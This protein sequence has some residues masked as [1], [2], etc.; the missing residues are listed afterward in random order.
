MNK[1]DGTII[2]K[3]RTRGKKEYNM[4]PTR[5]I[6]KITHNIDIYKGNVNDHIGNDE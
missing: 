1:N 5:K 2:M 4:T 3:T 6:T